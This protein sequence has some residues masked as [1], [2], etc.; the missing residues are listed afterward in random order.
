MGEA[1]RKASPILDVAALAQLGAD[2]AARRGLRAIIREGRKS[3]LDVVQVAGVTISAGARSSQ[4]VQ[5]QGPK[6]RRRR[7]KTAAAPQ[8]QAS[9]E[10]FEQTRLRR[11]LFAVL[12][13]INQVMGAHIRAPAE[14]PAPPPTEASAGAVPPGKTPTTPEVSPAR[15][16]VPAQEQVGARQDERQQQPARAG[17]DPEPAHAQEQQQQLSKGG[18]REG[19]SSSRQMD[20]ELSP[21]RE[22]GRWITG[23][24]RD[25][26][27]PNSG[28]S[29]S[30][31]SK[32]GWEK[33][34]KKGGKSL[35]DS[36]D[37]WDG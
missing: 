8:K 33:S 1:S 9:K 10:K 16:S 26:E 28:R 31:S 23:I 18:R 34:S 32:K 36:A 21:T 27:A 24:Q 17:A 6:P 4:Q 15:P 5:Q 19:G 3:G 25:R 13:I 11:K 2:E 37:I 20:T 35:F 30:K 14:E 22:V 12:P 7:P 29:K